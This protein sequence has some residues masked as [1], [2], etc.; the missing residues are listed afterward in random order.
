MEGH[1]NCDD[2]NC[3]SY[4]RKGL[5]CSGSLSVIL[6]LRIRNGRFDWNFSQFAFFFKGPEPQNRQHIYP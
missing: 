3:K 5:G 2:F 6:T 4:I 1:E